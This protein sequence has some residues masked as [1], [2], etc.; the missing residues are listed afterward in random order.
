MKEINETYFMIIN[1]IVIVILVCGEEVENDVEKE[2]NTH[3]II[4]IL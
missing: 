4:K 3:H 2:E 1:N